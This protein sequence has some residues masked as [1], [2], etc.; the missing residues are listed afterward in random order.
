M[1]V[2]KIIAAIVAVSLVAMAFYTLGI[3]GYM[4]ILS[5]QVVDAEYA[6]DGG[7]WH[8]R[9]SADA[10]YK[11]VSSERDALYNS[12]GYKGWFSTASKPV[13]MLVCLAA[14]LVIAAGLYL[15][16]GYE[17]RGKY[18][19]QYARDYRDFRGYR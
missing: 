8:D 13:Q 9:A 17:T 6:A 19:Y 18:D 14:V 2:M 10:T 5:N 11:R 12:G 15:V 3:A 16:F 1:N 7:T 4:V